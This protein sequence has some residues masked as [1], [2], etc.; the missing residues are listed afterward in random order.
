MSLLIASLVGDFSSNFHYKSFP[1]L[2][3]E[4]VSIGFEPVTNGF[5]NSLLIYSGL[6]TKF[7][8]GLLDKKNFIKIFKIKS[9]TNLIKKI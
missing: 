1:L 6:T 7:S 5:S 3:Q 8:N 9:V 2:V 4:S